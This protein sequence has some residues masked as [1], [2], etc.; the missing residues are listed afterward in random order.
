MTFVPEI[1][2]QGKSVHV[3]QTNIFGLNENDNFM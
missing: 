2:L 3:K 1:I